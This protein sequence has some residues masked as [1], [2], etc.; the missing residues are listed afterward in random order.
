MDTFKTGAKVSITPCSHMFHK[1]CLWTWIDTKISKS[2]RRVDV[3]CPLCNNSFLKAYSKKRRNDTEYI[4]NLIDDTNEVG[5]R[6]VNSRT[7]LRTK[8]N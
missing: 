4:T 3:E 6:R 7:R 5:H 1:S 8:T 2:D